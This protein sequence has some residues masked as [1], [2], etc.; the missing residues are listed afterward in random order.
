MIMHTARRLSEIGRSLGG[1]GTTKVHGETDELSMLSSAAREMRD[2]V[3]QQKQEIWQLRQQQAV[4][5]LELQKSKAEIRKVEPSELVPGTWDLSGWQD[6]LVQEIERAKRYHKSFCILLVR[7]FR[8]EERTK[9]IPA[10][11]RE[12]LMKMVTEK[13]R[14]MVRNS[15]LIAGGPRK[16][17]GI[18]LPET[19]PK[20]GMAVGNRLVARFESEAF[21]TRNIL[22]GLNFQLCIGIA[23]YPYD[24]RDAGTLLEYGRASLSD[25]EKRGGGTSI[26]YDRYTMG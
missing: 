26:R 10:N 4:L 14:G 13:L 5:K 20:G 23:S 2:R 25:A 6:Y 1:I 8:F 18:M 17:F 16:Y 19:D 12:E 21:V 15:D 7:V 11:E 24:A 3:D 22:E 9:E